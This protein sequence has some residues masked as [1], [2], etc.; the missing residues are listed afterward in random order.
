M[1]V[2][3]F[4][5]MRLGASLN[6]DYNGGGWMQSLF[7]L[8]CR[9]NNVQIGVCCLSDK[10]SV[11]NEEN[12]SFFT[13]KK[14]LG[15]AYK[16]GQFFYS[17]K[18]AS[19]IHME[20]VIPG[21]QKVVTQFRPD[22]IHV[23]GT[24]NL[25]GLISKYTDVPVVVH[26]QGVLNSCFE[27][28]LPPGVSWRMILF[29]SLRLKNI[30]Y[31]ISEKKVWIRNCITEQ[32]IFKSANYYMGRTE[33]DECIVRLYNPQAKYYKVWEVMRSE[34]YVEKVNRVYPTR[35]IFI[36]VLSWQLYKGLD[37][38]L[39]TANVLNNIGFNDF[40]W[41][42]YGNNSLSIAEKI[43]KVKAKD[44]CVKIM[45]VVNAQKLKDEYLHATAYVHPSYMENSSNAICEAQI[46]GC[47][48]I[49]TNVGGTSSL[50][51]HRD[52]GFLVPAND[53]AMMAY[54]MK[55]LFENEDVNRKIGMRC[56]LVSANRHDKKRIVQEVLGVYNQIIQ[57]QLS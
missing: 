19:R 50:I 46:M 3:W 37:F 22:I 25:Y 49:A 40:E 27:T 8:I 7:D 4:T 5:N 9:A 1:K 57:E 23:F 41:R 17:A 2:L 47:T 20:Q 29:S 10:D 28:F 38:I 12:K 43:T 13:I 31:N 21:L 56:R 42:I 14:P 11:I 39:R 52:T 55:Y 54:W 45:G 18:E 30:M 24:E 36:S 32:K 26:I 16:L 35:P 53:S 15:V 6:N 51:S 33:W 48:P 34:F 44:V